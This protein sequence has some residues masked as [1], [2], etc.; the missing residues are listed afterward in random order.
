MI[1]DTCPYSATRMAHANGSSAIHANVMQHLR[2]GIRAGMMN[3]GAAMVAEVLEHRKRQ[4]F[5]RI[6]RT[7]Q[8][9]EDAAGKRP[10]RGRQGREPV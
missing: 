4:S 3:T 5:L 6:K 8:T 2:D 10:P 9:L 7:L 1:T